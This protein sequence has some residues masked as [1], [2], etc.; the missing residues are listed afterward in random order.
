MPDAVAV[1]RDPRHD[2]R[3]QPPVLRRLRRVAFDGTEPQ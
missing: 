2:A 1:M 3:E